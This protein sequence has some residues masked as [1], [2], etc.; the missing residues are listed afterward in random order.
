M[1]LPN[2]IVIGAE[3]SG[4]TWLKHVLREHPEIY[5]PNEKELHFF[6]ADDNFSKGLS[7][8]SSF[9]EKSTKPLNGEI[10]P[11]YL[12]QA[13]K[14]A[15]RIAELFPEVKLIA[16]LR[17]PVDRAW[18]NYHM[19]LAD[20]KIAQSFGACIDSNHIIITKGHYKDQLQCYFELFSRDQL[21]ILNYEDLREAG[22]LVE[23]IF[24]FL[25]VEE[26]FV[27]ARLKEKIFTSRKSRFALLN[28]F[29]RISARI[30]RVL[31]LNS[32]FYQFRIGV[33]KWLKKV[34]TVPAEYPAMPIDV[35]KKLSDYYKEDIAFLEEVWQKDLS[36]WRT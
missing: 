22:V 25:G 34:N 16:I 13:E 21:L 17:N 6:D 3:K 23:H 28:D 29:F 10:T 30:L 31:K 18:S 2:F 27:P 14:V 15:P 32:F 9:F 35:R 19:N 24:N 11:G 5:I 20:G 7:W 12:A 36:E 8:Y 33:K 1:T 4:T 26:S